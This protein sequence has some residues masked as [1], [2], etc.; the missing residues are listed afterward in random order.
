MTAFVVVI[1]AEA[2]ASD[3]IAAAAGP[4][5][6]ADPMAPNA[7]VLRSRL[8]P[9]PVSAV[10][11]GAWVIGEIAADGVRSAAGPETGARIAR[12]LLSSWGRYVA[13]IQEGARTTVLRDPSGG[14]EAAIWRRDGLL[15]VASHLPDWL[16]PWLPPDLVIDE[17]ALARLVANPALG[18][19]A[20]PLRGIAMLA[21]GALWRDGV[22]EQAWRPATFAKAERRDRSDP[23]PKLV[24]AVDASVRAVARG[25]VLI[26]VS[27]GLDSA[28]VSGALAQAG[29][30][31]VCALNY[32]I[33]D[34]QGDER[35]FARA[36]A[37]RLGWT[38]VEIP[39]SSAGVDLGRL[40]ELSRGLRPA[41]ASFDQQHD[42]DLEA[43]C[44]TL[45]VDTVLTGQGGDHLFFQAPTA[46]IAADGPARGL[47]LKGLAA[48]ARWQGRSIYDVAW[49]ALRAG[50]GADIAL[51]PP[52]HAGPALREI[53][54]GAAN[55]PWLDGIAELPPAKALQVVSLVGA[56]GVHSLTRRSQA[57]DLRHPLISQPLL[58]LCLSLPTVVLTRGGRDRGLARD[59]FAGR[60]PPE[61]AN[62][63]TKGRLSSH[64][65]RTLAASLPDLRPLLL[66]GRLAAAGL[67]E[68]D[69]LD[70]MLQ[71]EALLWRGG[72]GILASL[73]MLEL[74]VEAWTARLLRRN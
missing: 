64:Y 60:L 35:P 52:P 53:R 13:V 58:E 54:L 39:K 19:A 21:P 73:T 12:R 32:Y 63:P 38:L 69:A 62:R 51:R 72:Y 31:V 41:L 67:V 7:L 48:L 1:G 56:L 68:R 10:A 5:W 22:V 47:T 18:A 2:Q 15:L 40:S 29:A 57:V 37:R 45:A 11:K 34:R 4:D 6:R 74:W 24:A 3:R 66:D 70:A 20:S 16:D 30:D 49:S 27:G 61:V 33:G 14:L 25:R 71:P 44:A 36:V 23:A 43:R 55:H 17:A 65:G 59:A 9:P 46:L 8:R 28:I 42:L 26:E 50:L